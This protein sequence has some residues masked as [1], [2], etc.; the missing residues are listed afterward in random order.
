MT[1][2]CVVDLGNH[3]AAL[4]DVH[5]RRNHLKWCLDMDLV[6]AYNEELKSFQKFVSRLKPAVRR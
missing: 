1:K 6:D 3:R 5:A 4:A 2:R